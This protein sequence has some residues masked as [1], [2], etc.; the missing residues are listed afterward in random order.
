M[1]IGRL[2]NHGDDSKISIPYVMQTSNVFER[3]QGL[4]GRAPLLP[5]QALLITSC[6]SI[7]TFF[8][9]YPIDLAFITNNWQIK[10][11]VHALKP[12]RLAWVPGTSMV[13]EMP[14]GAIDKFN[15]SEGIT[16]FWEE[17]ND[18]WT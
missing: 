5:G 8:M 17:K 13:L 12:F 1:I 3:M 6:S 18:S 2:S 14:A 9:R 10:K 11:L 4:L 15:L 16:L 7:H